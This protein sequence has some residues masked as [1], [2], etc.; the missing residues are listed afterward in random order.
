MNDEELAGRIEDLA[1]L[2]FSRSGGPGGQNVNK[3]NT[4]VTL[5]IPL[6]ELGLSGE[7]LERLKDSLSSRVNDKC[8]LVI[9]CMETRSQKTNRT[10]ALNRAAELVSKALEPPVHRRKTRPSGA[11]RRRRLEAKR[12]RSVIK[13]ERRKPSRDDLR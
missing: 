3:V 11:A 4:K 6:N 7:E 13:H 5:R 10:L 1:S 12:R 2:Q 8:E 9:H